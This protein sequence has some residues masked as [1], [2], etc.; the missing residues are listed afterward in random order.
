MQ[1]R[2]VDVAEVAA[3]YFVDLCKKSCERLEQRAERPQPQTR[4]DSTFDLNF[5]FNGERQG[6]F[7]HQ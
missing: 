2:S 3:T 7:E 1:I 5:H 4:I 6:S